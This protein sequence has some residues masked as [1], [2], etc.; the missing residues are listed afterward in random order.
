MKYSYLRKIGILGIIVLFFASN[1]TMA[2]YSSIN[3]TIQQRAEGNVEEI[4]LT[5]SFSEPDIVV[6][7]DQLWVYVTETDINMI[8]PDQP[9]LP[10]N[11]TVL[12]FGLGTEIISVDYTHSCPVIINLDRDIAYGNYP[13]IDSSKDVMTDKIDRVLS[14][15][16][17]D[18]WIFYHTGGG[19]ADEDHV[20]FFVLRVFPVRYYPGEHQLHYIEE[21]SV[22]ITYNEL[23]A[24]LI[25]DKDVYDLLIITPQKFE[26]HLSALACHK[27]AF[28]L[29][30]RVVSIPEI[31]ER[32]YW[33]GRDT[34]EK[35]KY[36]IKE[37]IEQWGVSYVLLVGGIQGQSFQWNLPVR[38]SHV[39]PP[40]E[41]EYAEQSFLSDLYFADIYD[42]LGSFSSWDSNSNDIF[43]EWNATV[44]DDMDCYPDVY[45]GRLPC[46]NALEVAVMVNKIITYEKEPCDPSWFQNLILVAG[47]SYQDDDHFN[48]GELISEH[49]LTLM[50]DFTPIKVY[51]SQQDINR[52]T[53]N[54]VMNQGAGFAYFCGHGSPASWSTH[55]PPNGTDWTT[56][57]DLR[58]MVFLKNK[59][60]L[61]IVVVGGCHNG[62]FDVSLMRILKGILEDGLHYF[63]SQPG[64]FGEFWYNEWVP[65]CW[66]WWL[67]SKRGGGAIATISNTGLGTHGEGDADHNDIADYLEILDGWLELRF[68]QLYGEDQLDILGENHGIS[69]TEYLHRFYGNH[70]KMD[71]KMVQQWQLFGDPSLK[72][73]G[74]DL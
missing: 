71:I 24:P 3:T 7:E 46:R 30:T 32:M 48:E 51:A 58:D 49:A 73:G 25:P 56:G 13:G 9:I 6:E 68:L 59:E 41:Q 10:A 17:P 72:I 40:D 1:F 65:N 19:L 12:E 4:T 53:V 37:A 11:L 70:D 60:K 27:N 14:E 57:Y 26:R 34:Q 52:K 18:D 54:A 45:L 39:V 29:K 35:M 20:T 64:N 5:F 44:K 66:S 36:Y 33:K 31:I 15:S 8:I 61:P 69:L 74:Y 22:N 43:A 63:S 38:Y 62:Q 50:P 42:S 55:F 47:D 21:M 16:Y 28:G 23:D 2:D 67:T